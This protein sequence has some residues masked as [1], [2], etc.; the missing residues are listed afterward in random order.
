MHRLY[1][2]EDIVIFWDSDKCFHAKEC[3]KGSPKTFDP[4]RRPWIQLGNAENAEV[5]QAIE[6]CPSG[7]LKVLY[8]HGID[9]KADPEQHRSIAYDGEKI[10]G[11]CEYQ[12]SESGWCIYHTGVL[13]GYEGKGIAKRLVYTVLQTAERKGVIVTATCSYAMRLL[14]NKE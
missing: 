8:R 11:E 2:N 10:I 13:T 7:A 3:R 14:E 9:V 6:K 4:A 5:W 1:E 12:E